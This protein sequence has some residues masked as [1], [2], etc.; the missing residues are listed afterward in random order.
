MSGIY[1]LSIE[2]RFAAAHA[3]AGYPGDCANIHGHNWTVQ[4][5]VRCLE[6]DD[7][8]IGIDFRVIKDHV[9]DVLKVL[10]HSH[11]NELPPFRETNPSSENVAKYLYGELVRRIQSER[12]RIA[13]VRVAE[14][15]ETGATYW[16]E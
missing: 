14:T 16:E 15:P 6:L 1:E 2:T 7:I 9:E 4:V 3:L 13:R 11:L 8:G 10:D 12:V 5:H